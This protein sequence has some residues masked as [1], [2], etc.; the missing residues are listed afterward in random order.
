MRKFV[1]VAAVVVAAVS[2]GGWSC[3]PVQGCVIYLPF[4]NGQ[5]LV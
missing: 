1:Y 2:F 3:Q 4:G 5:C